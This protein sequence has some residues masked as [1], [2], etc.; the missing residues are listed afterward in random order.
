VWRGP[1]T[2]AVITGLALAVMPALAAQAPTITASDTVFTPSELTVAPGQAVKLANSGGTH[3]FRFADGNYPAIPTPSTDPVWDDLSRTFAQAGEYTFMCG[4]HPSMTG[5]VKVQDPAATPTA[6]PSATATP[7]PGG[8]EPV[9]VR[10]LEPAAKTFCMRRGPRCAKPGVRLR[11]DL[12]RPAPVAGTLRRGARRFGRVDF[13]TVA[14]GARTLTFRRNAAGRR[15][16]AGRYTL[17]LRV[18][19]VLQPVLRFRVR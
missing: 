14:A 2:L 9:E 8:S 1:V 16:T 13:G 19:G 4:A 3:N 7:P 17:R 12:S 11:I 15:L 10:R 5:V 18:A 6:T